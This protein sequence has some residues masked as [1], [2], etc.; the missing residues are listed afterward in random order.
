M[1]FC[2]KTHKPAFGV[3]RVW[4]Y[5]DG[6]HWNQETTP[7]APERADKPVGWSPIMVVRPFWWPVWINHPESGWIVVPKAYAT[8]NKHPYRV[9]GGACYEVERAAVMWAYAVGLLT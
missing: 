1:I 9:Y 2:A 7:N 6:T 3:Q 5:A 8:H 4:F